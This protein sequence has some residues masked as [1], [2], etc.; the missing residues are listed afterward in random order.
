MRQ[1]AYIVLGVVFLANLIQPM[2]EMAETCR[3]KIVISAALNN[4]FRAARDRSLTEE[5]LQDLAAE[6]DVDLFY[7]YFAEAF[8]DSLDLQVINK[9]IGESGYIE[10]ESGDDSYNTIRVEIDI[11]DGSYEYEDRDTTRVNLHLET[12]YKFKIGALQLLNDANKYNSYTL[13]FDRTYLLLVKN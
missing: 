1:V 10:F 11:E 5:S 12:D 7:Q 8:C 2:T 4:S 6:V 9:G 13:E 3:Q